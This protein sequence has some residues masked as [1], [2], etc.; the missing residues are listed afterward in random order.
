MLLES[1]T[2]NLQ[3]QLQ[4]M[5]RPLVA[6]LGPAL[7]DIHKETPIINNNKIANYSTHLTFFFT[8]SI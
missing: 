2:H 4:G 8:K 6:S 5:Q 3:F 1:K 7:T